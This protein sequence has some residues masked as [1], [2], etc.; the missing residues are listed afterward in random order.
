MVASSAVWQ[1]TIWAPTNRRVL[2]NRSALPL[3]CGSWGLVRMGLRSS[4]CKALCQSTELSAEPMSEWMLRQVI[5]CSQNQPTARAR[6]PKSWLSSLRQHIDAGQ[7]CGVI[8]RDVHL[9]VS[10][11]PGGALT[12]ITSDPVVGLH[13]QSR[14][15]AL[16]R[17]GSWRLAVP[18]VTA[19]P[20]STGSQ[21]PFR[22]GLQ[23]F[24]P[25]QPQ[26]FHGPANRGVGPGQ[27]FGVPPV[28]VHRLR[29]AALAACRPNAG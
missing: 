13:A 16:V 29:E 1:A 14:Q 20:V 19:A 28:L 8:D 6:K 4:A 3:V 23:V 21:Q 22:P 10:G 11:P 25:S 7:A 24:G 2:I 26:G 15:P 17:Q 9:L 12:A 27:G 18:L 5:A